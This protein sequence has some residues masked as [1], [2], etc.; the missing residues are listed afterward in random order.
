M[1]LSAERLREIITELASRPQHKKVRA[2]VYEILVNGL[3]ARSTEL[4]FERRVPEVH[5]RIDA[6]LGRTLF[7][8]KSDLK[9]LCAACG[10]ASPMCSLTYLHSSATVMISTD[11][12]KLRHISRVLTTRS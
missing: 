3:G 8:F 2:L 7:E 10:G 4:D 6:L 11:L 12:T 1:P 9:H 5:G